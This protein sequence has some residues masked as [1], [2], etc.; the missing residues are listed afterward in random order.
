MAKKVKSERINLHQIDEELK[1][2]NMRLHELPLKKPTESTFAKMIGIQYEDQM[3]QLEKMKLNLES[4]KDQITSSIKKDT[5][6]FI[7]EMAP[8]N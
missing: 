5:D 8:Q 1:S 2:V 7:T 4:Q 6:T 3:E